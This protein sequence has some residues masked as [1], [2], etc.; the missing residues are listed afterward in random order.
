MSDLSDIFRGPLAEFRH[1]FVGEGDLRPMVDGKSML[2]PEFLES[3]LGRYA[4]VYPKADSVAV[5][6]QWSKWHFSLLLPP[7]VAALLVAQHELPV[8]LSDTAIVLSDD[9]RVEAFRLSGRGRDIT[10]DDVSD[11]LKRLI[12]GHLAPLIACLAAVNKAPEKVLWSN[13][14]NVLESVLKECGTWLAPDHSGLADA[15]RLLTRRVHTDGT[16]N[17]LFEP[18]RYVKHGNELIRRR[19]ICCLRY[20]IPSLSLCKS[21]PLAFSRKNSTGDIRS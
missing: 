3:L 18:V 6:T 17:F 8:D 19:K 2:A 20:R 21:C 9:G 16:R 4:R 14:G 5:A 15:N 1:V 12:D 11:S 7:V 13:A 10:A